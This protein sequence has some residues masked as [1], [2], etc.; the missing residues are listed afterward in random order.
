MAK[1]F[2]EFVIGDLDEKKVWRQ[3]MK[4]VD[5]LPEDYRFTYKKILNYGYNF[6]FCCLTQSD[7]LVLF[8]ERAAAGRPVR[9]IVGGDVAAFCDELICAAST[10]QDDAREQ[11]NREIAA[12]FHR[13]EK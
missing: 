6:G 5:A 3:M 12:H 10:R 13:E 8:E 1:S 11:L 9:E 2:L 7:L 4:R